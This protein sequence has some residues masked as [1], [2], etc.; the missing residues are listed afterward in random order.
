M[1]VLAVR[2]RARG[3]ERQKQKYEDGGNDNVCVPRFVEEYLRKQIRIRMP[4]T[5]FVSNLSVQNS[6]RQKKRESIV[7]AVCR[8]RLP[9]SFCMF[10]FHVRN[11]CQQSFIKPYVNNMN[12]Q[13]VLK[14]P[15]ASRSLRTSNCQYVKIII[16]NLTNSC[17]FFRLLVVKLASGIDISLS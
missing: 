3:V 5:I 4:E 13:F 10:C 14:F 2:N 11:H 1:A 17:R 8:L 9:R 16:H 15:Y 6:V 12:S 7:F